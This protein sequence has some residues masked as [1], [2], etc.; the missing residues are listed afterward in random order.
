MG[1]RDNQKKKVISNSR[2]RAQ[3]PIRSLYPGSLITSR[4]RVYGSE[5]DSGGPRVGL[6]DHPSVLP[7]RGDAMLPGMYK[8]TAIRGNIGR[9]NLWFF[10]SLGSGL[11]SSKV[12]SLPGMAGWRWKAGSVGAR[13]AAHT[14]LSAPEAR[15][16]PSTA[17]F[18]HSSRRQVLVGLVMAL[19]L[20]EQP[21]T[22]THV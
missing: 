16:V 9:C 17:A 1:D 20:L 18:P 4:S 6:C 15:V 7:A 21:C 10:R 11:G 2:G 8:Y 5:L 19:P 14:P 13:H 3:G 22:S 12:I